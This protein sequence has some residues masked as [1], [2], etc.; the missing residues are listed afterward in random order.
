MRSTTRSP[1][2]RRSQLSSG[3]FSSAAWSL[4]SWHWATNHA[5]RARPHG[6]SGE[7]RAKSP[8]PL[9]GCISPS[10]KKPTPTGEKLRCSRRSSSSTSD[11]IRSS[12]GTITW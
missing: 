1:Q 6:E 2:W 9:N 3:M 10:M 5:R 7:K 12:E 4:R 11:S 8:S